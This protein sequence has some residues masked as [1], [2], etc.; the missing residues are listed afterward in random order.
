[1]TAAKRKM[2]RNNHNIQADIKL[3]KKAFAHAAK[4]VRG[5]TT[6]MLYDKT[7]DLQESVTTYAQEK[8]LKTFGFAILAG[9]VIGY[10]IHK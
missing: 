7:A 3:I 10:I 5:K 4:D 8:P 1:M 2:H 6:D 9:V